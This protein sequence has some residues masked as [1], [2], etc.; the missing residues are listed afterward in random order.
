[1]H[2]DR[3]VYKK[4][5]YVIEQAIEKTTDEVLDILIDY[6]YHDVYGTG[7][8]PHMYNPTFE[9]IDSWV[10]K[11]EGGNKYNE[12]IATIYSEANLM[13]YNPSEHIHGSF[14][15]GDFR[16]HMAEA[17]EEG[18]GYKYFPQ[19][20]S[21]GTKN[22]A[23]QPRRFFSDTINALNRNGLLMKIFENAMAD[24]GIE[25]NKKNNTLN[26]LLDNEIV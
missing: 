18:L 10:K 26:Y 20:R 17:I 2:N 21:D 24:L 25:L 23:S 19:V 15:S 6:I 16:E 22:P 7:N 14:L 5:G 13:S 11:I 4:I 3:E 1:M 9:F 8:P 12:V